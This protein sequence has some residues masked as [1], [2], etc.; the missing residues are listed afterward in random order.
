MKCSYHLAFM[1]LKIEKKMK[2]VTDGDCMQP[3]INNTD[4]VE[5]SVPEKYHIG[6]IVLVLVNNQLRIHRIISKGPNGYVT[7]GDHSYMADKGRNNK[8]LGRAMTNDTQKRS[9][10]SNRVHLLFR[11]IVSRNNGKIYRK[12]LKARNGFSR[13]VLFLLYK[14]GDFILFYI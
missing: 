10:C 3:I 12:Y 9:L 13:N 1:K 4:I 7:K 11:T 5:V 14:F 2:I 8:I 6:D